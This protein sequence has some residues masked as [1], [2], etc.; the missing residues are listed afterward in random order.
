MVVGE[1]RI[2]GLVL[3]TELKRSKKGKKM[4]ILSLDTKTTPVNILFMGKAFDQ[5]YVKKYD[6]KVIIATV[7]RT[8]EG[9]LFGRE[10]SEAENTSGCYYLDIKEYDDWITK[11]KYVNA[12][13][14]SGYNELYI[15]SP[16][17]KEEKMTHARV[18]GPFYVSGDVIK[19]INAKKYP[20]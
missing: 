9:A 11:G 14:D 15:R 12:N 20:G 5:Y 8:N 19:H 2:L 13:K 10:I 4:M 16:F 1:N 6:G 3:K 18:Y 17:V 7:D